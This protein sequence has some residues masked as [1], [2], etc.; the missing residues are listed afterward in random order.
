MIPGEFDIV[1]SGIVAPEGLKTVYLP[2]WSEANGQDDVQWYTADRQAD[3]TIVSM[4]THVTIRI[5]Q[6]STMFTCI[7]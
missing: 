1:V 6:A 5:M 2:T 7:T 3:G 4:F